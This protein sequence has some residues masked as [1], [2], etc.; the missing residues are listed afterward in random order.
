MAS[1][2][3]HR[4]GSRR[5]WPF[6]LLLVAAI[7]SATL[8]PGRGLALAVEVRGLVPIFGGADSIVADSQGEFAYVT[9]GPGLITIDVAAQSATHIVP[10]NGTSA[11]AGDIDA[12]D[13]LVALY[14]F[15]RSWVADVTTGEEIVSA[16][17]S[18]SGGVAIAQG[19]LYVPSFNDRGI[20]VVSL[21]GMVTEFIDPTGGTPVATPCSIVRSPD[22]ARLFVGDQSNGV[23]YVI[24]AVTRQVVSTILAGPP[25]CNIVALD[26]D[27]FVVV[28]E[29]S[30]QAAL[31]DLTNPSGLPEHVGFVGNLGFVLK[32]ALDAIDSTVWLL[33]STGSFGSPTQYEIV[34]LALPDLGEVARVPL[35][36][37]ELGRPTDAAL[38]AS[39]GDVRGLVTTDRGVVFMPEPSR[40]ASS[41]ASALALGVLG[42]RARRASTA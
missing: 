21:D 7:G 22:E 1:P 39:P 2:I 36:Q 29:G 37:A 30:D 24:D 9:N 40:L 42:I 41:L 6:W 8:A 4:V 15:S 33:N 25:T 32:V 20:N 19:F 5:S 3:F 16:G 10:T 28:D 12:T 35:D 34:V 11:L 13:S 23:V 26:A 38:V 17:A 27:R 18:G 31:F 14:E